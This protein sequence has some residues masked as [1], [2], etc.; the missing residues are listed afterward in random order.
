M[1]KVIYI[2]GPMTGKPDFNFPAF[3]TVALSLRSIGFYVINPA[4]FGQNPK[5]T[6][7]DC[8]KRDL[9]AMFHCDVVVTL[10]GW[11]NSKGAQLETYVAKALSIPVMTLAEFK[12]QVINGPPAEATTAA[13]S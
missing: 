6:W 2:S 4:D 9:L 8:L 12:Q 10:P 11:E 7:V 5:L 3:N 1:S 13:T